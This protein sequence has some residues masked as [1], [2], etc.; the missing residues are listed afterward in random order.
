MASHEELSLSKEQI[1]QVVDAFYDRVQLDE[2]LAQPFSIVTDWTHH[3]ALIS[4][5]WWMTLGGDRYMDYSYSVAPKHRAVGFTP[6]LLNG[7]WLP[8]FE[9]TMREIL[10]DDI[11]DVW[12]AQARRIGRSLELNH[13]YWMAQNETDRKQVIADTFSDIKRP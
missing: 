9:R 11:A 5:F 2:G 12:M 1:A 6:D 8:L 3:K 4:H 13:N 7:N 10:P